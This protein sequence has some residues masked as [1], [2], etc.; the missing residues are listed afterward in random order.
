MHILSVDTISI[1]EMPI[2]A[3]SEVRPFDFRVPNS[4]LTRVNAVG[5]QVKSF[6]DHTDPKD[7]NNRLFYAWRTC[8]KN[9]RCVKVVYHR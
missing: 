3:F 1:L 5:L 8:G 9:A 6:F 7:P 2:Q 4:I